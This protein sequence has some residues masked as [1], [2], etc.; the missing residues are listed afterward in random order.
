VTLHPYIGLVSINATGIAFTANVMRQ[1]NKETRI[2]AGSRAAD[3]VGL[4]ECN[5]SLGIP[6]PTTAKSNF[7]FPRN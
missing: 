5:G 6:P 7:L 2:A 1:V 4:N 3:T